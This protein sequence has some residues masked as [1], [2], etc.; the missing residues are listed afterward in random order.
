M[1]MLT[2]W[3]ADYEKATGKNGKVLDV[4]GE[5]DEGCLFIVVVVK[6]GKEIVRYSPYFNQSP[7]ADCTDLDEEVEDP[8]GCP[9][10]E[11]NYDEDAWI[12]SMT[13]ATDWDEWEWEEL[14]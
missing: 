12:D 13:N 1:N 3:Q 8:C 10:C 11:F 14:E 9:G 6:E 7:Y 2:Q 4:Y 5:M